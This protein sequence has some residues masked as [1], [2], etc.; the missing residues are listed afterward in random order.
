MIAKK[1]KLA[2]PSDL[3]LQVMGVLWKRGPSTARQVMDAMPDGKQRAYTTVLT[4]MQVL[5]K[6]RLVRHTRQG[7]ANV[8]SPAVSRK[9][10]MRPILRGWI[11]KIFGGSPSAAVQ[12]LL[13]ETDV[14]AGELA[15]IE[16]IL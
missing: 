14:D 9:D 16:E 7:M 5:E 1:S 4:V 11:T 6:K 2:A 15:K 12:Q 13:N 10:V 3:E 8:Y